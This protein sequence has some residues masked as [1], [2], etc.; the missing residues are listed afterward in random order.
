MTA[1]WRALLRLAGRDIRRQPARS[2]LVILLVA[3]PVAGVVVATTGYFTGRVEPS[4]Q[5]ARALGD[6]D[7]A[8][9]PTDIL[10]DSQPATHLPDGAQ[11]E[12]LW[13]GELQVAP[14]IPVDGV[15][16]VEAVGADLNGLATGMFEVVEGGAPDDTNEIALTTELA[17]SLD[18]ATGERLATQAGT[19]EVS[20]LIRDPTALDRQAAVVPPRSAPGTSGWLVRLPDD[21]DVGTVTRQLESTGWDVTTRAEVS[22]S[23]PEQLLFILVLGGFGFVVAALVT[24]AAFAVSAQ[25]RQHEL[26]LLAATGAN[27]SHLRRSVLSSAMLL[28][29]AGS[30]TG[31]ATGV[32]AIAATLPWL[33]RW[34]NRAIE[35]VAISAPLLAA[36][37]I[38]GFTTSLASAWFTARW[39]GRT[40][41]AAALA[42]R[43]PPRTSSSRLL[44]AGAVSTGIGIAATVATA[45]AAGPGTGEVITALGLLLGAALTMVGLGAMS[46]WLVERIARRLGSRLPV[47]VRIAMRDTARFRSRSG[48]IVMA[49]VAG[50][51]VSIAVGATLDTIESG[52]ADSYR[53]QLT[54]EQLIVDGSAPV[55][56]VQELEDT[57][58]V[59]ATARLAIVQP[60]DRTG[61][62]QPLPEVV[63][64]AGPS[65]LDVLDTPAE[66]EQALI[67]GKVLTLYEPDHSDAD[68]MGEQARLIA[69]DG[70]HPVP[71]D[72]LPRAVPPIIMSAETFQAAGL[73]A[74]REGSRWILRL[75]Q[76]LTDNQLNRAHQL[77]A[78]FGQRI[79]V[80]DGPPQIASGAI[81]TG[82]TLSA[83]VLSLLIV[84]VGLALM[85][86]ETKHDDSVLVAVGASPQT[87][88]SLAAARA[89]TLTF[90][91]A[92]LAVPAGLLPIWGLSA[93]ADSGAAAAGLT[94][95][96]TVVAVVIVGAP[97]TASAAAWA[98]ARP[99]EASVT[100]GP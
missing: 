88:R 45:S 8:I 94:I 6:A 85:S 20:G 1:A 57:L 46:P 48:P 2:L 11:T 74:G 56:L 39:A 50:L 18:V 81:Q 97:A 7:A 47:G 60:V 51:G 14:T 29:A 70:V 66:A 21:V 73:E 44:I 10:V 95:P 55:P 96:V 17:K 99:R 19:V 16:Q 26:A 35:G 76:P 82:A 38:V 22:R 75:T 42:G 15:R 71:L 40:P 25:R 91:G 12:P 37:A 64:V 36:A 34:T 62:Q 9:Y 84:G 77:A 31:V 61:P 33:E 53:P 54:E 65:L 78:N 13:R 32:A 23:N 69:P 89:G 58:P 30:V 72:P 68:A 43:R 4:E 3:L 41:V 93:A 86:A 59:T 24:A 80:E 83:A 100:S 98:L 67:S 5:A 63:T 52:L 27:A 90:L 49:I 79:T 92:A 28:G 87:R